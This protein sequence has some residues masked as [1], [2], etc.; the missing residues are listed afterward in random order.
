MANGSL[1]L[2]HLLGSF[3]GLSGVVLELGDGGVQRVRLTLQRLHLLA[4]RVH[5]R[6]FYCGIESLGLGEALGL[7]TRKQ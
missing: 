3:N 2:C 5:L 1:A 7:T 6:A 4:D